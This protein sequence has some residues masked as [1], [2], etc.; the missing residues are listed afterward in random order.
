MITKKQGKVKLFITEKYKNNS[1]EIIDLISNPDSCKIYF[2][3]TGTCTVYANDN[4]VIKR[5]NQKTIKHKIKQILGFGRA[6]NTFNW[7]KLLTDNN[8]LVSEEVGF[9]Y[10]TG[11][12]FKKAEYFIA[13]RI[14]GETLFDFINE[15]NQQTNELVLTKSVNLIKQLWQIGFSH[16]DL[17][18]QNLMVEKLDDDFMIY[19]IDLDQLKKTN[20]KNLE[21]DKKRFLKNFKETIYFEK[22]KLLF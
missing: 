9:A 15:N 13:K 6:K 1:Q 5:Y 16:G 18:S 22:I 20:S 7:T 4:Y 19:F 8:I 12:V 17:K 21:K 2:K 14:N 3:K 10:E 11:A